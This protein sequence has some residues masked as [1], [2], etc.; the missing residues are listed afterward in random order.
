[1][2]IAIIQQL[3]RENERQIVEIKKIKVEMEDIQAC[4]PA[5]IRLFG[6]SFYVKLDPRLIRFYELIP[7]DEILITV[8]K[9]KREIRRK[10]VKEE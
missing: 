5:P 9:A 10:E 4:F 8:T 6:N 2:V 1:M 3:S 7:G